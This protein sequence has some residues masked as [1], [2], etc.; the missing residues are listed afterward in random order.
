MLLQ[1]F[2]ADSAGAGDH[3]RVVVGRDPGPAFMNAAQRLGFRFVII[4]SPN[5]TA[6]A[7]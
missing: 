4:A 6:S 7:P 5:S 3:A 2:D 1:H